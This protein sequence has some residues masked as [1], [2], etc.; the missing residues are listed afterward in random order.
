MCNFIVFII[1]K[2]FSNANLISYYWTYLSKQHFFNNSRGTQSTPRTTPWN[3]YM[4]P[5]Y[6]A[7]SLYSGESSPNAF[8]ITDTRTTNSTIYTSSNSSSPNRRRAFSHRVSA[9][10]P[11]RVNYT[12]TRFRRTPHWTTGRTCKSLFITASWNS[13]IVNELQ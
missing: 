8:P 4:P 9:F 3:L 5:Y 12:R 2:C 6:Y 13:V 10:M 11:T 1:Y 7:A